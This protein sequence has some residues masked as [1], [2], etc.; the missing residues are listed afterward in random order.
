MEYKNY[1]NMY[2]FINVKHLG[3]WLISEFRIYLQKKII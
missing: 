1:E 3:L 2:V